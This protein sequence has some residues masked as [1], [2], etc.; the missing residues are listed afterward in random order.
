MIFAQEFLNV[1]SVLLASKVGNFIYLF[2]LFN[3]AWNI[4][5]S[6]IILVEIISKYIYKKS[7][8]LIE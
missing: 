8:D 4:Y 3:C 1:C 6:Y 7:C 2:I 5:I